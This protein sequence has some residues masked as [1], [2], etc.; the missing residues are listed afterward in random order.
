VFFFPQKAKSLKANISQP[1]G[2]L[3]VYF[4]ELEGN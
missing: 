4:W 3:D 1:E 2:S